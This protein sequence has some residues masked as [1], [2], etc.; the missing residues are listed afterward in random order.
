MLILIAGNVIYGED[1][2][3]RIS[4]MYEWLHEYVG[5]TITHGNQGVKGNGW[6]L[7]KV[8]ASGFCGTQIWALIIYD[9]NKSTMFRLKFPN[10]GN[11]DG[12]DHTRLTK[13]LEQNI[14]RIIS[15]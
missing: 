10:I 14:D 11:V 12:F 15:K 7:I 3:N 1:Y 5:E 9:P 13:L 2:E 6:Q 8:A 4:G